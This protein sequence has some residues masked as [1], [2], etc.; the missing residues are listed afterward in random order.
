MGS[1]WNIEWNIEWGHVE[2]LTDFVNVAD[3]CD[4]NQIFHKDSEATKYF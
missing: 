4:V 1:C 3:I 2:L